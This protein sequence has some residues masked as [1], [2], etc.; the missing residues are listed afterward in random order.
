LPVSAAFGHAINSTLNNLP[1]AFQVSWPWMLVLLP[2]NLGVNLYLI[3]RGMTSPEEF[4]GTAILLS[5]MMGIASLVAF[6]SIAVNWHRYILIDEVPLGMQRLRLDG[7]VFRYL[8][9]TIMILLL[10]SIAG[11]ISAMIIVFASM[12]LGPLAFIAAI[13]GFAAIAVLTTASFYRLGVK[14][15]AIAIGRTDYGFGNAWSD[16]AGNLWRLFGFFVLYFLVAMVAGLLVLFV[17]WILTMIGGELG[18]AIS[19]AAQLVVNWVAT[20][21]GVTILTSLYG[22]F[23]EGRDF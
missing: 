22:F 5:M 10:I 15:P 12:L 18:I 7:T 13:P 19:V 14:L 4:D 2:I 16:T 23:G 21:L 1:F 9:N 17:G 11:F 6:S 8:G 3:G 20:I